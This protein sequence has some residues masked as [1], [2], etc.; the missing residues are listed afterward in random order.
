MFQYMGWE[1]GLNDTIATY[2]LTEA[3]NLISDF[4]LDIWENIVKDEMS[5][6]VRNLKIQIT[7]FESMSLKFH[8]NYNGS[9]LC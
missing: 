9:Q 3:L 6:E 8:V 2:V 4:F 7:G 5:S 1:L